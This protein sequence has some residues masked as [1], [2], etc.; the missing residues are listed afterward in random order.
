M[1]GRAYNI[2]GGSRVTVNEVLKIVERLVG[3]PVL[4]RRE[5]AQKGDMRDTLCGHDARPHGSGVRAG[6]VPGTRIGIGVS[7]AIDN[8]RARD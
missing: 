3:R 8:T 6:R 2:G 7:M 1:P 4:V 5:P